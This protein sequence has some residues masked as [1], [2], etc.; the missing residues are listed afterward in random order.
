MHEAAIKDAFQC[1]AAA[2]RTG[3]G[4]DKLAAHSHQSIRTLCRV[5][6]CTHLCVQMFFP[7]FLS[8]TKREAQR[9]FRLCAPHDTPRTHCAPICNVHKTRH[10]YA[11]V[12]IL[13]SIYT[14]ICREVAPRRLPVCR[15][16]SV[17]K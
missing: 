13:I 12:N 6:K 4:H 10:D 17:I 8:V 14:H 15:H 9:T 16:S 11:Q 2:A 7:R 3:D 1:Q 5:P